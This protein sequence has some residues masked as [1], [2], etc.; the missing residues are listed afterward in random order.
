M[1]EKNKKEI[2][3]NIEGFEGKYQVSNKGRVRSLN[4]STEQTITSCKGVKFTVVKNYAGRILKASQDN[5]GYFHVR[6]YKVGAKPVLFKVH[7]LVAQYFLS[8]YNADLTVDH[9]DCNKMNNDVSNLQMLT[10]I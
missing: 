10:L 2:W 7:K 9:I 1:K 3:K 8:D 4:H 5:Y 6:L